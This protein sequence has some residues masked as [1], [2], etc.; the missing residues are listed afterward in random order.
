MVIEHR[1]KKQSVIIFEI[2]S[3][4]VQSEAL[5]LLL[6][7][8]LAYEFELSRIVANGGHQV[9]YSRVEVEAQFF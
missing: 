9:F 6:L 2:W 1:F 5:L 7:R 4:G 3:Y 8:H